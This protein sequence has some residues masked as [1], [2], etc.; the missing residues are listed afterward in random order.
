MGD[1]V[2]GAHGLKDLGG[3]R[4]LLSPGYWCAVV[5]DLGG[6]DLLDAWLGEKSLVLLS[7]PGAAA[8]MERRGDPGAVWPAGCRLD[9][10]L[11]R[12]QGAV[13]VISHLQRREWWWP[14]G[15]AVSPWRRSGRGAVLLQV[16]RGERESAAAAM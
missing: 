8:P 7:W 11:A 16:E 2:K 13:V 12:R 5:A 10:L 6:L 15:V 4:S 3:S 1:V 14:S 9:L